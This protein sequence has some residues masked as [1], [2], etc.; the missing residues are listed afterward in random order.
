MD[1][2]ILTK[3]LCVVIQNSPPLTEH[4]DTGWYNPD[5]LLAFK[6]SLFD[7]ILQNDFVCLR[8]ETS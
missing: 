4:G 5:F 8:F 7:A 3:F 6:E 1:I 2:R